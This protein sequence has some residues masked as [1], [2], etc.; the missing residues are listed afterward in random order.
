MADWRAARE[1][2][3]AEKSV[4]AVPAVERDAQGVRLQDAVNVGEGIEDAGGAV[5]LDGAAGAVPVANQIRRVGQH[6]IHA[7]GVKLR[8]DVEAITVEDGI[9]LDGHG[10]RSFPAAIAAS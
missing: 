10:A 2:P 3:R 4:H 7:A 5:V 1:L 6:E 9:A 8:Q